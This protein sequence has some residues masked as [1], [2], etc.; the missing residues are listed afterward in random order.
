[1]MVPPLVGLD[2]DE[3]SQHLPYLIQPPSSFKGP[4][5]RSRPIN[6]QTHLSQEAAHVAAV[7]GP[8]AHCA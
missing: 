4:L 3:I 1:M 6:T 2:L 5:V 7:Q 8:V